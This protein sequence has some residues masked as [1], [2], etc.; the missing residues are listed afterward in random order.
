[1]KTVETSTSKEYS[2]A[3]SSSFFFLNEITKLLSGMKVS[4][5]E[6]ED[7]KPF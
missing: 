1:M 5:G 3:V 7:T 6:K 4:D 2:A